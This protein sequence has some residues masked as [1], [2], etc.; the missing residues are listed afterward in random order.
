MELAISEAARCTL[1]LTAY[2]VGAVL[3]DDPTDLN[4]LFVTGYSREIEG[5]T[6]AEQCCILK[7]NSPLR[8]SAALFTT[9]EP[10]NLRLS[11]NVIGLSD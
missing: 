9:M 6:H 5:N 11:G 7:M 4:S 1:V 8:E 2:S 10:C 3:V